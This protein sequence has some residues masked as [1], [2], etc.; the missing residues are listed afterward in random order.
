[1][2]LMASDRGSQHQSM[3]GLQLGIGLCSPPQGCWALLMPRHVQGPGG[4]S[5]L[6]QASQYT[7]AQKY[8]F[9]SCLQVAVSLCGETFPETNTARAPCRLKPTPSTHTV[10]FM[11]FP[12]PSVV[13]EL[14]RSEEH[15]CFSPG[16][17]DA[18]QK[19]YSTA[20]VPPPG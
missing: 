14:V 17:S 15:E 4:L 16:A 7:V 1:M 6:Q 8:A 19:P 2:L 12:M 9:L 11:G 3:R 5:G 10:Q 13:R 18:A 20:K